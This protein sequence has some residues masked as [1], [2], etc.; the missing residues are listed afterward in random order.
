[1]NSSTPRTLKGEGIMTHPVRVKVD[2]VEQIGEIVSQTNAAAKVR[3]G[4]G[5]GWSFE[6]WFPWK[7]VETIQPDEAKWLDDL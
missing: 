2:G 7:K 6:S 3:V 5:K 4:N 1:L